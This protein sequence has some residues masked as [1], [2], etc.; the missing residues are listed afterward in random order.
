M[1]RK[2]S[3]LTLITSCI[4]CNQ[5]SDVQTKSTSEYFDIQS[6]FKAEGN[7]LKKLNPT[8]NKTVSIQNNTQTKQLKISNWQKELSSFTDAN[9]N[10][11]AW[12]GDFKIYKSN[13]LETYSSAKDKITVKFVALQKIDK[14]IKS[15]KIIVANKN[16]LYQ[17]SDTLIYFPDSLIDIKKQQKI[18][19][20]SQ[21]NYRITVK[22]K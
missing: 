22:F 9:I 4:A 6:Y 7:R 11:S 18:R 15:I 3:L 17:S 13:T 5:H 20:L 21:K 8:V 1:L 10:K 19:F 14:K 16:I 12:K 2:L